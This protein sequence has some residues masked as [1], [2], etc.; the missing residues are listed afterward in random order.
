MVISLES[1][2]SRSA[3]RYR[4]PSTPGRPPSCVA[5][6]RQTI[7][8]RS[9]NCTTLSTQSLTRFSG[10]GIFCLPEAR[11]RT[12]HGRPVGCWE[13]TRGWRRI[14]SR[15]L[16]RWRRVSRILQAVRAAD[17]PDA[18][19]RCLGRTV[20]ER[21]R[22]L[23]PVRD[24]CGTDPARTGP[25][26]LAYTSVATATLPAFG[27]EIMICTGQN[28]RLSTNSRSCLSPMVCVERGAADDHRHD[29][30][31]ATRPQR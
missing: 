10:A 22:P 27:Q 26:A 23:M 6:S 12:A 15:R 5:H 3:S 4:T 29:Q 8:R 9:S 20:G 18:W 30:P 11:A 1:D 31:M 13:L 21:S 14:S 19:W 7:L 25:S 17:A 28:R 2:G 16:P 24:R